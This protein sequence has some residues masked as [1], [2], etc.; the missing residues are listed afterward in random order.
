MPTHVNVG[1]PIVSDLAGATQNR[2]D[3]TRPDTLYAHLKAIA[4][5]HSYTLR[6]K[7][8][9]RNRRLVRGQFRTPLKVIRMFDERESMLRRELINQLQSEWRSRSAADIERL[10]RDM[11]EAGLLTITSGREWA[12]R[13]TI[14]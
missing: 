10:I 11:H 8:Y 13:V 4:D 2:W 6:F 5:N 3:I 12:S 14:A 9:C 7:Q 1:T